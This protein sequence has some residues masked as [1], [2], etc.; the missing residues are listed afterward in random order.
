MRVAQRVT[1]LI[2][3]ALALVAQRLLNAR[4]GRHERRWW[5]SANAV[6]HHLHQQRLLVRHPLQRVVQHWVQ[7]HAGHAVNGTAHCVTHP[8][9]NRSLSHV[10]K[11]KA[12]AV[13]TPHR[14]VWAGTRW[15]CDW[16]SRAIGNGDQHKRA[17]T[18]CNPVAA[19]RVVFAVVF[20]LDT[21]A[22]Q[23]QIRGRNLRDRRRLLPRNQ[24]H[25]VVRRAHARLR[26]RF[27]AHHIKNGFGWLA[28]TGSRTKRRV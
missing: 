22:R 12:F 7:A 9:F 3:A 18:R 21:H 17:D 16:R 6:W 28:V 8:Q 11:C 24:Q 15:Q 4:T 2:R 20:R 19:R 13:G 1:I 14:P 27:G 26:R 10:L 23:A 25:A 5:R